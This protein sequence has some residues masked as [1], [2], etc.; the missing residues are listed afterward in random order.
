PPS[1][2]GGPPAAR[3]APRPSG[4]CARGPP[5]AC[6]SCNS[7][8]RASPPR[9]PNCASCCWICASTWRACKRPHTTE[10]RDPRLP[11]FNAIWRHRQSGRRSGGPTP[12][13]GAA[14]VIREGLRFEVLQE[15]PCAPDDVTTEWAGVRVFPSEK[16]V[17]S[18]DIHCLYIPPPIR[19]AE[20]DDRV[21]RFSPRHLPSGVNTVILGDLNAHHPAWDPESEE[22][23]L[24]TAVF[25]WSVVS[26][27]RVLNDGSATHMPRRANTR[28]TAPDVSLC[29]KSLANRAESGETSARTTCRSASPS[30]AEARPSAGG[31][32]RRSWAKADW[33]SFRARTEE[34]LAG[35]EAC[36]PESVSEAN[37]Q[38]TTAIQEADKASVPRG[39][40]PSAKAWWTPE[41][42][43]AVKARRAAWAAAAADP[44]VRPA[45]NRACADAKKT[46]ADAK[47]ESW[48]TF[49]GEVAA[50]SDH[51]KIW[52]IVRSLDG[53]NSNLQRD[54]ALRVGQKTLVQSKDIAEA[55]A[56]EY[57]SVSRLPQDRRTRDLRRENFRSSVSRAGADSHGS[58]DFGKPFSHRELDRALHSLPARKAP[59]PDE[60]CAE[61]LQHLGAAGRRAVLQL[62]NASWTQG[63]VPAAWRRAHI[64]PILKKGKPADEIGSY[65][66]IALTSTLAKLA[67]RLVQARLYWWAESR[68]LLHPAQAG[69]RKRR[70]TEDQIARLT[71]LISDGHQA[72]PARRT[73]V[74]L[75]DFRR[76]YDTVWK[77]GLLHKLHNAGIPAA[78][79]RWAETKAQAAID[80]VSDWANEWRMELAPNKCAA[81]LFTTTAGEASRELRLRLNDAPLSTDRQPRFLGVILD[82]LLSF[83]AHAANV[84][85]R[86]RARCGV[87]AALSGSNWGAK[88]SDVRQLYT[89]YVR[90]VLEYAAGAWMP[91]AC[92]T[93][94]DHL[95]RAQRLG[96]RI[97]TGC[98]RNTRSEVL[99][100]EAGLPPMAVRAEMHAGLLHERALRLPHDNPLRACAA[101]VGPRRRLQSARG[102]R[103]TAASVCSAAGLSGFPREPVHAIPTTPPWAV[104]DS[105]TL[106]LQLASPTSRGDLPEA[107]RAAAQ[108]T[109][110][111]LPPASTV[112][113]TDGA[114]KDG[115]LDGGSGVLVE[116][117]T[118][119]C[120]A[121]GHVTSSFHA[122]LVAI[123][124]ALRWVLA[125]PDPAE[126]SPV[127]I[128][129]D[130]LSALSALAS[131]PGSTGATMIDAVWGS[132][133]DLAARGTSV[134][135]QWV[136]GHAGI[137]GNEAVDEI[138]K[139]GTTLAQGT[140]PVP[141]AAAQAAVRRYC[142]ARWHQI[143]NAAATEAAS[144]S[145]LAWHLAC[146]AGRLPPQPT[147][148]LTRR[149]ER[150]IC[151]LR[152]DRCPALRGFQAAI[153]VDVAPTCRFCGDGEETAAHLL[154]SCP[155]LT[156]HRCRLW[157]PSPEPAA[158]FENCVAVLNFLGKAGAI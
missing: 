37:Q 57:A 90:P 42:D 39:A 112:I 80:A 101:S 142:L 105:V 95:D 88:Q 66:P 29:H 21:Q 130:S 51:S 150:L 121:A 77:Q 81:S 43:D 158:V 141:L 116:P 14:I 87:L 17:E 131:G 151:Q 62:I 115:I 45:W 8:Q 149:Q 91:T 136:P 139:Q 135:L 147:S 69:F 157:G 48:R 11:G 140:A 84:A 33:A 50:D 99:E 30:T 111:A 129:S 110:A 72:A 5:V 68:H 70:S 120:V 76:A 148:D 74:V 38:L 155:A 59:G 128:C 3:G 2:N 145:S 61:H 55:Y 12:G 85:G 82:R 23:D 156:S 58:R 137:P 35:W 154:I 31:A 71:Q 97:I 126:L 132:L 36:P 107:R 54:A 73:V 106:G 79:V 114:A 89:A 25:E 102:W 83:T 125:A 118:T 52:R 18:L 123:A 19:T 96:A 63:E 56:R 9:C 78:G 15:R 13:G 10:G 153:G 22:S 67:E 32:A 65:R 16:S 108:Q 92:R 27:M 109:L 46:I 60:I 113:W 143:Y 152:A 20:G 41:V 28:Q 34:A 94:I 24:G 144:T 133:A 86:A 6:T 146:T 47:R 98:P 138:A 93:A 122:E 64:V 124:E 26:G 104:L 75:F 53:R 44:S 40:R 134:H 117:N 1:L 127:R 119:L 49:A 4:P 100:R 7:T 103:E